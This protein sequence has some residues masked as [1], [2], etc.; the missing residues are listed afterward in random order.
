MKIKQTAFFLGTLLLSATC[1][2]AEA[3]FTKLNFVHAGNDVWKAKINGKE[4]LL[5][6][7]YEKTTD[8]P[9]IWVGDLRIRDIKTGRLCDGNA[10]MIGEVY[11]RKNSKVII[12]ITEVGAGDYFD[13]IDIDSCKAVY[14]NIHGY[15]RRP[16]IK[17][18]II[19]SRAVCEPFLEQPNKA[20]CSSANVY[21]LDADARPVWLDKESMEWTVK[22]LGVGFQGNRL[23]ENPRTKQAKLLPEEE[24]EGWFSSIKKWFSF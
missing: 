24:N 5:N 10:S 13:F 2:A 15:S 1:P 19:V 23:V 8:Q 11:A 22:I 4:I 9:E 17:N 18:N 20:Y 21:R 7:K 14:P 16:H 3:L 12:A 6:E